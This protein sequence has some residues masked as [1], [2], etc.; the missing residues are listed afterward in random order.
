MTILDMRHERDVMTLSELAQRL[1]LS[2]TVA[3]ERARLDALPVPRVPGTGRR[4]LYSRRAYDA[5]MAAQ[6][7]S[8]GAQG[9]LPA[10]GQ[11]IKAALCH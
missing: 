1:G 2:M 4:Y 3:H 11:C 9:G 8:L 10:E 6:H 7:V 5:L